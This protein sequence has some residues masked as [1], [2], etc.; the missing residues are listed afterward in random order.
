MLEVDVDVGRFAAL[1]A[2]ETF[3]QQ[4]AA[5][6]VDRGDA[7]HVTHR[8]VGGRTAA[9]AENVLRLREA[10]DAVHGEEI[11]RVFQLRI[12]AS[13]C[14]SC[15]VTSSGMPSGN[16]LAAP[17]QVRLFQRLL[18]GQTGDADLVRILVA[19]LVEGE[20]APVGDFLRARDGVRVAARTAEPFPRG[21]SGGGRRSARGGT[22]LVDGAAFADAGQ[23]VL[24]DAAARGVI[25]HIA[26][27]DG[28]RPCRAREF[29]NASCRRTASLGR[30]R[31]VSA[32]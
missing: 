19:Q 23:H 10:D 22:G 12:S 2:D 25:Q 11:R 8:R 29:G 6:G 7:K 13:S 4:A 21:V 30:R 24:Q 18:R 31:R 32:R 20:P 27:S 14:W 26:G 3:E 17:S 28:G 5:R 1:G 16:A 9:L 15:C